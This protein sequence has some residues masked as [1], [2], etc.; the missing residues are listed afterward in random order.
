VI[1]GV[2]GIGLQDTLRAIY[3][4]IQGEAPVEEGKPWQP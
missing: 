4:E 2:A 3:R 1:S